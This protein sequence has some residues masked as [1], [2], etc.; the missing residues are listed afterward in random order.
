[1]YEVNLGKT[2][3]DQITGFKGV[4]THVTTYM[5]GADRVELQPVVDKEGKVPDF[6]NL[7][8]CQITITDEKRKIKAIKNKGKIKHGQKV[9][10]IVSGYNGTVVAIGYFL[11]G[12][13]RV[14]ILRHIDNNKD[15]KIEE[16][17]Y[18][19]EDRLEVIKKESIQ[20]RDNSTG[21]PS[22]YMDNRRF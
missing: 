18:F 15:N 14:G 22:K 6:I 5:H 2:G 17:E 8:C 11:N 9:K 20:K 1:M 7:D 4:I 16:A 19:D 12:C 21:G 3:V 13:R 10:D